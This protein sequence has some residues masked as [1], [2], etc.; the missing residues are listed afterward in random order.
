MTFIKP[1]DLESGVPSHV[2][3]PPLCQF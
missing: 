1:F 2:A 3:Y